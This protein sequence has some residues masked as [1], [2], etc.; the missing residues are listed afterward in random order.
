[1]H[2][3][4][5]KIPKKIF[6]VTLGHSFVL[7]V[8]TPSQKREKYLATAL[9]SLALMLLCQCTADGATGQHG[10]LAASHVVK[11]PKKDIER[12]T[13]HTHNMA[14]ASASAPTLTRGLVDCKIAKVC[15]NQMYIHLQLH[16]PTSAPLHPPWTVVMQLV[17]VALVTAP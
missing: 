8:L 7:P 11:A 9:V 15:S 2:H 1:M 10:D 12:A 13:V 3:F 5:V 14:D 17:G 6:L 4:K 16:I